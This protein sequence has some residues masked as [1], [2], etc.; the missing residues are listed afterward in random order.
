MKI[1]ITG[2]NGF[3]G[4]TLAEEMRARGHEVVALSRRNGGDVGDADAMREALEGCD[5]VVHCAGIN[6]EIGVQTY[7][8]VHVQGT[9]NVVEAARANG[10]KRIVLTSFLRAR[11]GCG[12]RYHES[13]YAAEEIVR[14]SGIDHVIFKPGVIYGRGDHMLDHM[15]RALRTFPAFAF[16]G[17]KDRE[18]AP[19]H[20]IDFTRQLAAAATGELAPG[21]YAPLGPEILPLREAVRRVARAA[22]RRALFFRM[23]VWFHY[24]LAWFV[25]RVMRVPV[26]SVAQVRILSE[27]VTEPVRDV[28][29]LPASLAPGIHFTESAIQEA[30]PDAGRY[31][32]RDLRLCTR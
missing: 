16:V 23:P 19:L 15:T 7:R 14:D 4:A 25:E 9:H 3:V 17:F 12:S 32:C 22:G 27:G 29:P 13:K 6:R 31:G 11:P 5:A 10:V 18:V 30:L 26:V 24:L 28:Q 20:V 8:R 1:A 21:T 2:G